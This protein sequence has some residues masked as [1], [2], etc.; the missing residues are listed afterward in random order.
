MPE[1]CTLPVPHSFIHLF[2]IYPFKGTTKGRANSHNV[3]QCIC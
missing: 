1:E 3:T 2:S